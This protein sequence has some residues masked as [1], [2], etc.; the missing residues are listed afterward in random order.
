M[1][2]NSSIIREYV[3][4]DQE[5]FVGLEDSKKSW[6]I[7]VRSGGIIVHETSMPAK[8][9]VLD[10][11][12]K[13][14]FPGCKIKVIYEAGF[15][16]FGL[17]DELVADGYDCIV[18]PPH[19]VTEEKCKRQKNDRIDS[20]RLATVL[21][22]RDFKACH[23]PDKRLREDRQISRLYNQNQ[24]DITRECNRIRRT[25]EF[26]DLDKEFPSGRWTQRQYKDT[27]TR[28]KEMD[29]SES[30][31]FSLEINYIRL[32]QLWALKKTILKKLSQLAE[33]EHYKRT[34]DLIKSVPGIGKLTGIRL[35]LEIGDMS[36]FKR[37]EQFATFIG[38]IP[39]EYSTGEKEKKGHITKQGNRSLRSWLIESAWIAIR[40]DPVL[41]DKYR[42]VYNNNGRQGKKAIVAVAKKLAIRIRAVV[43]T[44]QPYMVGVV[45]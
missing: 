37:K 1:I 45:E 34:V 4:K 11:Y 21:E 6:K 30:L 2:N 43:L 8:Y 35:I 17:H 29:L 41:L 24:K 16:G 27:Q 3:L 5:I 19:T 36:R 15:K 12:F 18:T 42:R 33:S 9:E 13:N 20:R 10:N 31:R 25:L 23:V 22:N 39:S 14:R 7:C 38:L 32:E 26:H 40:K 28:L 44:Q